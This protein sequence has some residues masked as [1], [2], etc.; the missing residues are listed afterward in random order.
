MKKTIAITLLTLAMGTTV[1]GAESTNKNQNDYFMMSSDTFQSMVD[2]MKE[3]GMSDDTINAMKDFMSQEDRS[4]G[5]MMS[6]MDR[7]NL[8][9]MFSFMT[10][11]YAT[12]NEQND[13]NNY[14][15]NNTN[16]SRFNMM[17][18][19]SNGYSCHGNYR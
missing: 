8:W 14:S 2:F 17:G 9:E 5:S 6:F 11:N 15:K 3:N 7:D 10:N 19:N 12:Y 16:R 4:F 1:F 13:T 18:F